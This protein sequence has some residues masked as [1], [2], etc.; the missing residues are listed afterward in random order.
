M[1]RFLSFLFFI[2]LQAGGWVGILFSEER[3]KERKGRKEGNILQPLC[4]F[5]CF[6]PAIEEQTP[7][8]CLDN[9]LDVPLT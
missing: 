8:K 9:Q 1:K 6:N 4:L 5:I 7:F 2:V 3:R